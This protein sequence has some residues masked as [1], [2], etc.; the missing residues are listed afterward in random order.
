MRTS[1]MEIIGSSRT[2]TKINVMNRPM[3]PASVSVS[4]VLGLPMGLYLSNRW[5]WHAPFIV[6]AGLGVFT[7]VFAAAVRR[8]GGT[9]H[10]GAI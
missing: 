4:Q 5:D 1:K 9:S 2:N 6:L 3:V 10:G 8:H 7:V